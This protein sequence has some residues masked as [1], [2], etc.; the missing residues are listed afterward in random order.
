MAALV[1]VHMHVDDNS[2][3]LKLN[4]LFQKARKNF[5]VEEPLHVQQL[6]LKHLCKLGLRH[7]NVLSNRL[8]DT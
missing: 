4:Y 3:T 6:F 7:K 5:M 8:N 1:Y 2:S